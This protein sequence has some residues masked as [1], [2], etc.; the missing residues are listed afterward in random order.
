M[1]SLKDLMVL[2]PARFLDN[3]Y[4]NLKGNADTASKWASKIN[5]AISATASDTSVGQIDGAENA[6]LYIPKTLSGFSSITATSF[7]GTASVA[8]KLGTTTIGGVR[9]PIY[10]NAGTATQV[11]I[12]S[13]GAWFTGVPSIGSD[14]VIELGRYIDFHNSNTSTNDYDVRIDAASASKN[15][16]YLP[17][18]TGQFVVH[19]NDTAIGGSTKPVYIAATGAATAIS[20]IALGSSTEDT[21][22]YFQTTKKSTEDASYGLFKMAVANAANGA[23]LQFSQTG[24]DG[25]TT[26]KYL[27]MSTTSFYPTEND[28]FNLGTSNLRW[29]NVYASNFNGT[30]VGAI[31]RH[32]D[33]DQSRAL[34]LLSI[35]KADNTTLQMCIGAHNTGHSTGAIWIKPSGYDGNSWDSDEG[36]YIAKDYLL[37]DD[38]RVP[39]TQTNAGSEGGT[40][41]P[42][43]VTGGIIKPLSATV[44]SGIKPVYL[45]AGTIT[46][47]NSTVGTTAKPVYLTAGTITECTPADVF[48]ALSWSAGDSS[49]PVLN[50][51]VATKARTATIPSASV[52]ASGVVTTETQRFRGK[53]F[54]EYPAFTSNGSRYLGWHYYHHNGSTVVGEHWYDVGDNTN[55]TTGRYYWR[56]YSPNSTANTKTTGFH[57]TFSLPAVTVGRTEN[58]SYEIFTSKSYTTLDGRYLKKT[59]QAA[60][61]KKLDAYEGRGT[62]TNLNKAANYGGAGALFHLIASSSTSTGKCPSDANV[63]QMNWDN[64]GGYDAQFAISTAGCRAYFRDEVSKGTA[65]R[66]LTHITG[67]TAAGSATLP[68]YVTNTG[69]VTPCTA[70]SLF[71]ALSWTAGASAG[72]TLSATVAGQTRTAVIPSASSSASGIVTTGT[73]TFGGTKTFNSTVFFTG[74]PVANNS[75]QYPVLRFR[76]LFSGN[77]AGRIYYN[78]GSETGFTDSYFWFRVYS[79]SST[80]STACLDYYEDYSLPKCNAGRTTNGGYSILTT[81]SKVTVAQG[82]TGSG[83]KVGAKTN[84]GITYGTALPSSGEEGDIFFVLAS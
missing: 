54:F 82:G 12:P 33:T 37:L 15:V 73:Q 76:P 20:S 81:K 16:L 17:G 49:G 38:K 75:K 40:A 27:K 64:D 52:S 28:D 23:L 36:L 62:T 3:I 61:A 58:A 2:G 35:Y 53:K 72:P 59:A 39:T 71:S 51:T 78:A 45:N 65:W 83:T 80:A 69:R 43:Y 60:S 46:V 14:G 21:I 26:T 22:R 1:A 48:S 13:S 74:I 5:V 6:T 67:G 34:A 56:Q 79:Y 68:V 19:T 10:L 4:G 8:S 50:V 41:K 55:I 25:T 9:R 66:E 42:V 47:S 84:L 30:L 24:T 32:F 18:I 70:S 44:G 77:D 7:I 57:E 63:L 29:K 11:S 31:R